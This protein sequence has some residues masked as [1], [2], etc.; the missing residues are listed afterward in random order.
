MKAGI[1][2][3]AM[4]LIDEVAVKVVN[5][6]GAT[7]P[8]VWKELP[9]LFFKFS[10]SKASVDDNIKQVKSIASFHKGGKFEFARDEAEQKLLWSARKEA[11]WSLLA[12]RKEGTVLWSTDV[13]VPMSRLVELVGKSS[14]RRSGILKC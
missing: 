3:A 11:L 12:A 8:R 13:A 6:A 14:I 2:I 1:P 10:G 4:E 7:A 9:T 5:K